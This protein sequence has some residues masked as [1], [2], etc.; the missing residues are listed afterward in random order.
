V[1]A[2]HGLGCDGGHAGAEMLSRMVLAAQNR[3]A[4]VVAFSL[5]GVA[6]HSD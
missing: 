4:S 5:G 2:D 1:A 6:Q 3:C